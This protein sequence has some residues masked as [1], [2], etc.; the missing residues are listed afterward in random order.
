MALVRIYDD[1]RDGE[2]FPDMCMKCGGETN[3]LVPKTFVWSPSWANL[4]IFIGL[5]PWVIVVLVTRKTMRV[6]VPLCQQHT[7]HWLYRNLYIGLGLLFWICAVILLALTAKQLPESAVTAG[8]AF[9]VFGGLTWLI[10]GAIYANSA[11]RASK[12]TEFG[13]EL[14]NVNKD[15]AQE[16]KR[17]C[18]KADR[19]PKAKRPRKDEYEDDFEKDEYDR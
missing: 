9:C 4:F 12:I 1:E 13:I 2:D 16:W 8:I 14:A 7:G 6:Q 5:L 11:I 18:K 3:L 15:F 19:R 17:V 10:S